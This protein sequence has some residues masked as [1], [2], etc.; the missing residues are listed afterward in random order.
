MNDDGSEHQSIAFQ[1]VRR[2]V[3]S[4]M[5]AV[6]V[7]GVVATS[8]SG[9]RAEQ[10][11]GTTL[12]SMDASPVVAQEA[13]HKFLPETSDEARQWFHA[14]IANKSLILAKM[15]EKLNKWVHSQ[16]GTK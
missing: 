3:L 1:A 5:S 2:P 6:L 11:L 9:V 15:N 10:D 8:F 16:D 4:V 12:V 14:I 13:G 7:F